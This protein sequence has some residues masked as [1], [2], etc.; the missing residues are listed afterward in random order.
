MRDAKKVRRFL[1]GV[2]CD[3][4]SDAELMSESACT[5]EHILPK[6]SR[7]WPTWYG[8]EDANP[9]EWIHRIGNLTLL[10]RHDN[11]PGEADNRDFFA[12]R[13]AYSRSAIQVTRD[14]G[15]YKDWTPKR[16]AERQKKLAV[17]AARVW[18][19]GEDRHGK[20]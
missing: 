1:F 16:V 4:Q 14:V 20:A 8:F 10:G 3:I 11:K 5:I 9:E 19:F 2:N 7:H 15:N 13:D 6:A 12:K 18:A 17:R